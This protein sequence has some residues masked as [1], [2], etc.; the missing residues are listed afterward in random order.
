VDDQVLHQRI[1]L[2]H[3]D[4]RLIA[5]IFVLPSGVIRALGGWLSDKFGAHTVTWWVM[6]T[7]CLALFLLSYPQH[8]VI[9]KTIGAR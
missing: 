6:W 8:Q 5:A 3:P 9:I 1:R 4:R 2:R 7:S